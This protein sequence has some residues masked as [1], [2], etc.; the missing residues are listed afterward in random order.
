[1]ESLMISEIHPSETSKVLAGNIIESLQSQPPAYASRGFLEASA[2][3]MNG[4]E[5]GDALGLGKPGWYYWALMAGQCA[6]FWLGA[7]LKR[8]SPKMDEKGLKVCIHQPYPSAIPP[9]F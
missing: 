9:Y 2:R 6:F 4:N 1:M 8:W 5:L 3:W 7:W